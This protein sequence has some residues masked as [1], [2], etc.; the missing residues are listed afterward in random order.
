MLKRKIDQVLKNWKENGAKKAL[1]II[2]ARQIGKTTAVREFARQEYECSLQLDFLDSADARNAFEKSASTQDILVSLR[3]LSQTPLIPGKTLIL[4]DEIQECPAA[5]TAVKYL[6]E[7]GQF[8]YIETGSLLGVR[9]R[10]VKSLPVGFE[11]LVNMYPLDFEEFLWAMRVQPEVI[12]NLQECYEQ[13]RP[14]PEAVHELMLRLFLTY[15]AVG[16]MPEA[17]QSFVDHRDLLL[18]SQIQHRIFDLYKLDI[19]QYTA[20]SERVKVM[21]LYKSVPAQLNEKNLRFYL[22]DVHPDARLNRYERSLSWLIESADILTSYS[23]TEPAVPLALNAKR[24]LFRLFM[25]DTGLLCAALGGQIQ[26]KI[27][28][29]DPSVNLGSVMENAF[30]QLFVSAGFELFYFNSKKIGEVDFVLEKDG[31]TDLIE[32]KS[33]NDWRKHPALT[34]LLAAQEKTEGQAIVFCQGNV[35]KTEQVLYLPW[36]MVLF[37]HP[38]KEESFVVE[39]NEEFLQMP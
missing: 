30:A 2:G 12:Q 3:A 37:Y 33:G 26:R 22:T 39:F 9:I 23:V 14:V 27:I 31:M 29:K 24:S 19:G 11:E 28:Q 35:E 21:N 17:V 4:L 5:R 7:D 10:E 1:C 16:G 34:K 15:T 8:D 6:V 13:C 38:Q 25:N 32:I 36:Y 18:V 20:E